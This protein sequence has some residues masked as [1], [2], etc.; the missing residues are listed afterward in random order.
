MMHMQK[1][2][3]DLLAVALQPSNVMP[4]DK[5]DEH[6]HILCLADEQSFGQIMHL[7]TLT[8]HSCS[9]TTQTLAVQ[10]FQI[11][12]HALAWCSSTACKYVCFGEDSCTATCRMKNNRV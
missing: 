5:I 7:Y 8:A 11:S 9:T 4:W 12:K 3:A 6:A 2:L 1:G 10:S